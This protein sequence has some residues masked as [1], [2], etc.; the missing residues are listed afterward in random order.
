MTPPLPCSA[1]HFSEGRTCQ[2]VSPGSWAPGRDHSC[3]DQGSGLV[4]TQMAPKWVNHRKTEEKEKGRNMDLSSLL[5]PLGPFQQQPWINANHCQPLRS[6]APC[7]GPGQVCNRHYPISPKHQGEAYY[8][9]SQTKKARIREIQ[10]SGSTGALPPSELPN[11]RS[12]RPCWGLQEAEGKPL[13]REDCRSCQDKLLPCKQ[14]RCLS[15]QMVQAAPPKRPRK[16]SK[17]LFQAHKKVAHFCLEDFGIRSALPKGVG[18]RKACFWHRDM[19][20]SQMLERTN[21]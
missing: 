19:Q 1:Q 7:Q 6:R 15:G 20:S 8:P 4:L 11:P 3:L 14:E 17:D 18:H 16:R 13:A 9:I 2:K 5:P 12:S 10:S 21:P